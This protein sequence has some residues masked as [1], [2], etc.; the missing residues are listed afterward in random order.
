MNRPKLEDFNLSEADFSLIEK[1]KKDNAFIDKEIKWL[2]FGLFLSIYFI[3]Q[4]F[5]KQKFIIGDFIAYFF[6]Y[7]YFGGIVAGIIAGA[8]G[9]WF[10]GLFQHKIPKEKELKEYQD[11]LLKYTKEVV[12][13]KIEHS[14]KLKEKIF[15]KRISDKNRDDLLAFQESLQDI[16]T[17]YNYMDWRQRESYKELESY[18]LSRL[19]SSSYPSL[20]SGSANN[21]RS[22]A[23]K[24]ESIINVKGE[25]EYLDKLENVGNNTDK[26]TVDESE[27]ISGENSEEEGEYQRNFEGRKVDFEELNKENASL[28]LKGEKAIIEY[29]KEILTRFGRA[30]LAE[31]V[32]HIAEDEG[33]GTGYDVLSFDIEGNQKKIEVKTTKRNKQTPFILSENEVAFMQSELENCYLYRLFNFDDKKGTGELDIAKGYEA[34]MAKYNLK[35]SQYKVRIK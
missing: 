20:R 29:E 13:G 6:V 5:T 3:Y 9:G 33:A 25:D 30:D 7:L 2:Y 17:L 21:R 32:R 31:Q 34:I 12:D 26:I 11:A 18:L 4:I 1:T 24:S 14:L 10:I 16:K 28:G 8:I 19:V 22:D 35:P 15:N 27:N 23:N